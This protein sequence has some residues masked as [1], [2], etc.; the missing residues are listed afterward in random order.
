MG[1]VLEVRERSGRR[2]RH[3]L[4]ARA[5]VGRASDCD[6]VLE[7]PAV[8]KR[9]LRLEVA[10]GGVFVEDLGSTNGTRVDGRRLEG[11]RPLGP[12]ETVEVGDYRLAVVPEGREPTGAE[13]DRRAAAVAVPEGRA[14]AARGPRDPK[15]VAVPDGRA[16]A[17][18]DPRDGKA[19]EDR[20][21]ALRKAVHDRLLEALD[22]RRLD[23]DRLGD[24]GLRQR[25][26]DALAAIVERMD[27]EGEIP[28]D[29][30]RARLR[31]DVFHE[32]LGLGPLDDLL[33]DDGV[34]EIMVNG[35]D[36]VW[37]ERDG[38]LLR[39]DLRFSSDAAVQ[40]VIERIVAP[41]GRRIDEAQP[42]VDARLPDGSRVNAVIP[43]LAL[44]GPSIT[45]R[46]FRR[47]RMG[48]ADLL[49]AGSLSPA[50]ARFLEVCIVSR[51]NV[52]ISGGTGS[53]KTT[54]LNVLASFIPAGERIVTIEDAAEL[55]LPQE[56]WVPLEARPPNLEGR[57]A[58]S[59]RDLVKNALRMR[60]DRIV[61]GECRGGEALDMLQA[62]NTGHDGSLTT[63]H[64]NS[65]RDALARIETLSLMSGMELPARAIRE[66]IASAV[67]VIVQQARFPD[68]SRKITA[69]SEL[70]GMEGDTLAL[71]DL[72]VFRE[73]GRDADGRV[74]GRFA[75]TGT[76][77]RFFEELR[78]RGQPVDFSP[79]AVEEAT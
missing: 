49:R 44:K 35:A 45:I 38:R 1:L 28:A 68:G 43:P 22:L 37:V 3:V 29:L 78:R 71:Q 31:R 20:V 2:Q 70:C 14:L 51:R 10:A 75:A 25:A 50:M 16:E 23:L 64:A 74:R 53:G 12:E 73:E 57:G 5:V 40:A 61:V 42:L 24:A 39:T 41:V 4:G 9:H 30:D 33:A 32:A 36:A 56:H 34:S 69:V 66:Q 79:F 15:V 11:R 48:M 72:F 77:P 27:E 7:S 19:A 13:G 65:P 21:A 60:P 18:R 8:S 58:I 6:L 47:E 46:K 59:I 55:Q 17:A 67:D 76:V 62:M 52:V 26:E 54:L 63:L